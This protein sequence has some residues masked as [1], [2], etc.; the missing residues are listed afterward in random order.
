MPNEMIERVAKAIF[1]GCDWDKLT[2][3][4]DR[5]LRFD[6]AKAAIAA[7]RVPTDKMYIEGSLAIVN[8]NG[9]ETY[10]CWEAMID[11][12]LKE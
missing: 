2:T 11:A 10:D 9:R 12:A 6:A 8:S 5:R 7:M 1:A 4:L 3:E